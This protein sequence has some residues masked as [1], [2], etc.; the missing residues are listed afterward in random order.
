MRRKSTRLTAG[1]AAALL[2]L[3][4][5]CFTMQHTFG[6]GPTQGQRREVHQWYALY[7]LIAVGGEADSGHLIGENSTGARITTQFTFLD[8]II[9]AFTSFATFYRQ[10]IVVEQ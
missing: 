5:A 4:P 6:E 8:V 1:L 7:G 9:T 3:L 2:A 10:T